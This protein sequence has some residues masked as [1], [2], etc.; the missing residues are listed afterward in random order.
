[1]RKSWALAVIIIIAVLAAGF[2]FIFFSCRSK[3]VPNISGAWY[4]T[5]LQDYKTGSK[6]DFASEMLVFHKDGTGIEVYLPCDSNEEY[7]YI[8]WSLGS[9]GKS[10]LIKHSSEYAY[11]MDIVENKGDK[12]ICTFFFDDAPDTYYLATY[13]KMD[14]GAFSYVG[15]WTLSEYTE[16]GEN[17]DT[18]ASDFY[19]Y[20]DKSF[21][22]KYIVLEEE[23]QESGTWDI[24][25]GK[26]ILNWDSG[27]SKSLENDIGINKLELYD[28]SELGNSVISIYK[29]YYGVITNTPPTTYSQNAG[30]KINGIF[31]SVFGKDN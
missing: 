12:L 28:T 16:N 17:Y 31:C 9:S 21:K 22:Q 29:R 2:T 19:F 3:P 15:R 6:Y 5:D 10:L 8:A 7:S 18:G 4:L 20:P 25:Q 1:M 23:I 11:H 26:L 13:K 27:K 30:E 24:S 14:E